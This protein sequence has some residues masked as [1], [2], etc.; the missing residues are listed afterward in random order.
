MKTALVTGG[1]GFLGSHLCDYLLAK[2]MKVICMDNFITG[3]RNNIKHLMSNKNFRL[4]END[5]TK[6]IK[7]EG[8]IDYILHFASPASPVD[9][10]RLPV[11]IAMTNSV[12]TLNMLDLAKEK[13]A[14]LLFASTSE[15]YGDPEVNPQPETYNGNVNT[16]GV[17]SCYDESKRFAEALIM[18]YHRAYKADVR[19]V[20][21]FNTYG[22]RMR[23]NDG[24][25]VPS[26]INQ[27]LE[28]KPI[29][30]F[31]DGSQTRSFCYVDDEVEG[32]YRLLMSKEIYP[33]NIGNPN[34][35]SVA[36]FAEKVI[37]L[38]GSRSRVIFKPLPEHDPKVRKPDISKARKL[39][40]WEPKISLDEGLK[41]TVEYF[42][43]VK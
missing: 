3:S 28:G 41:R 32:I 26:F 23:K 16:T 30:V 11:E 40:K 17:R 29:T 4:I 6:K 10:D 42:R 20:R 5:A 36:D 37:Q 35:V 15:C 39:L 12:G 22:P 33:T 27:A 18:A 2:G 14:V 9:F 31:G 43:S 38:T 34:E 25:V 24:R 13:K 21:I 1:A 19:I 7:I 8:D